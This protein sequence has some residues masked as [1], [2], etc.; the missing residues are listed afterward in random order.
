[1]NNI[2]YF[3]KLENTPPRSDPD[4]GM[5]YSKN[6][7]GAILSKKVGAEWQAVGTIQGALRAHKTVFQ[8]R[9][10]IVSTL[11]GKAISGLSCI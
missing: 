9:I 1:M 5:D 3:A 11:G 10:Y 8:T 7:D 6:A 2:S 4:E